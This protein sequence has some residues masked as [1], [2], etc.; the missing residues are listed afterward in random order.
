MLILAIETSCDD[1]AAAVVKDGRT[2][3]SSAVSG[4]ISVHRPYNG[5]VP[6]LASRAHVENVN[7]VIEETLRR[8]QKSLSS[9]DAIAVTTGPGL[10]GS[11]LVG[12]MTAEAL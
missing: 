8:A 2:V 10:I 12:K 3:L 11:L 6:E 4:Q 5:V 9:I 7:A 1:S